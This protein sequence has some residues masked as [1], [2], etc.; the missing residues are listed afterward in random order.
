MGD[1]EAPYA[2]DP[3]TNATCTY[4]NY[5]INS[6]FSSIFSIENAERMENCP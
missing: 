6:P 2:K 4:A 1:W 3:L 5:N